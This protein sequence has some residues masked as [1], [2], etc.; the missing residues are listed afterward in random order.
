[1]DAM[2]AVKQRISVRSYAP[3]GIS[4]EVRSELE[5]YC[6]EKGGGPF[7]AEV[8]FQLLDLEPLCAAELR[9]LGTYG[10]IKGARHYILAAVKPGKGALEDLGYRME[11]IILK[12]TA[13]GLGTCWLGGLFKR[14]AFAA[15]MD[16]AEDEFMPAIAAIGYP[17]SEISPA[18]RLIRFSAGSQK[19]KPWSGLFFK[20]DGRTP[21]TEREAG[22]L[23]NA[24]EAVR[25]GPSASN[26]QP[27]RVIRDNEGR[28][29]FYLKENKFFNRLTGK[30]S[31]QNIDMGIAMCHFDLVACEQGISGGW[32]PGITAGI[33]TGL[34][35]IACWVGH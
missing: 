19:R 16:L 1:M 29:H 28:Y 35:H 10:V 21:L 26:R 32:A 30:N 4:D 7:E 11:K 12:A 33:F 17:L 22:E 3:K 25:M 23:G 24:L 8:R 6:Y 20:A 31:L 5:K 18:D 34:K 15:R 27:W 13:L 2:E 14:S 9:S